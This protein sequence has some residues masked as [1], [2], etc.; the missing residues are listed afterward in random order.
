[1]QT[2]VTR[3]DQC[4]KFP[5]TNVSH[6][7]PVTIL[8]YEYSSWRF[9]QSTSY[10]CSASA[11]TSTGG[12]DCF[13]TFGR[14]R[15]LKES[16]S[17]IALTTLRR[18]LCS[19]TLDLFALVVRIQNVVK[20]S[21]YLDCLPI[22]TTLSANKSLSPPSLQTHP[23]TTGW[24]R[25]LGPCTRLVHERSCI[26]IH[27][28]VLKTTNTSHAN[29]ILYCRFSSTDCPVNS[30]SHHTTKLP[31]LR[32]VNFDLPSRF[33]SYNTNSIC[34]GARWE[35]NINIVTYGYSVLWIEGSSVIVLYCTYVLRK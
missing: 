24:L 32:F 20:R 11:S 30:V 6:L 31:R 3:D 15:V 5:A 27:V 21:H 19:T 18:R 29:E 14:A 7:S 34:G 12:T 22:P 23:E 13:P 1:M 28:C 16:Y 35:Q 8:L 2:Q 10:S 26:C 9:D 33:Q 17:V 25:R 4:W